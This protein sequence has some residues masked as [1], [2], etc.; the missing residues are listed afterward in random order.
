MN[1]ELKSVS[2]GLL[3]GFSL[4]LQPLKM[5]CLQRLLT[6]LPRKILQIRNAQVMLVKNCRMNGVRMLSVIILILSTVPPA[7]KIFLIR[8]LSAKQ[9]LRNVLYN[10]KQQNQLRKRRKQEKE[11]LLGGLRRALGLMA[12]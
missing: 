9:K 2:F 8:R 12:E 6:R 1:L 11:D 5:L 7:K 3:S 10:R 4:Q